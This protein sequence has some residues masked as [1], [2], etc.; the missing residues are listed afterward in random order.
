MRAEERAQQRFQPYS[1]YYQ[2]RDIFEGTSTSFESV[3]SR[4]FHVA[5]DVAGDSKPVTIDQ[6]MAAW[7]DESNKFWIV[8]KAAA[9]GTIDYWKLPSKDKPEFD[10]ARHKEIQSLLDLGALRLLSLKESLE[11][12][13][14]FP[15]YVLPSRWVDRWKGTDEQTVI[16]KSRLVVLGFR[17]PHVLQLERSAPTPTSEGF[18]SVL[19]ILASMKWDGVSAD[20]KNAFAQSMPTNRTQK[21]CSSLPPNMIEAGFNVDPRQLL[22]CETEVY[23]LISGPSWLR[24]SLVSSLQDLGYVRNNY[25]KCAMMLPPVDTGKIRRSSDV[26]GSAIAPVYNDG[27][28][29]I[30]VDDILEGGSARHRSLMEKFYRHSYVES[31]RTLENS[32]MKEL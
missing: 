23:G 9:D 12:R 4:N 24:Q 14:K 16:A 11:F 20:L 5:S 32:K 8:K 3:S 15:D 13:E 31:A 6:G 26:A 10:R 30:E 1:V 18:T 2:H 28:V 22:I 27:V 17:D 29:L 21:I 25:E 7:D 19:Q